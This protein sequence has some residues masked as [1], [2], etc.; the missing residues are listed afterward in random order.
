MPNDDN[1]E[2]LSKINNNI[3][4]E[5]FDDLNTD[6]E[7]ENDDDN[8]DEDEKDVEDVEDVEDEK[9]EKEK[10]EILEKVEEI[11]EIEEIENKKEKE[12]KEVK[13]YSNI[14]ICK[15][16][17]CS[18]QNVKNCKKCG[19]AYCIMHANRY[20][21]NF[22]KEC[23]TNLSVVESKF[24]RTFEDFDTDTDKLIVTKESCT[25]YYMDG[26]DWPF[27]NTWIDSLTDDELKSLWNFHFFI[28][29]T[30]EAENETRK[31][32]KYKKLR[33]QPTPKLISQVTK[34]TVTKIADTEEDIR[35][36]L[37]KQGLPDIIIEQMIKAMNI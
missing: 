19:R 12:E 32:Q 18:E 11:E 36:K 16:N 30:I 8:D 27:I 14:N 37:K 2:V 13:I 23:F 6:V 1:T 28:M 20:S 25:K 4:D 3:K 29:K 26:P 10:I 34:K 33:E 9:D 17:N 21:P 24:L 22:C 31:I 5:D 15:F 7:F 35:K